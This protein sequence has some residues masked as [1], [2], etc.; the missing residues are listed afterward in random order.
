MVFFQTSLRVLLVFTWQGQ[1][2]G[3]RPP[4]KPPGVEL[5]KNLGQEAPP[6]HRLKA[7]KRTEGVEKDPGVSSCCFQI[8]VYVFVGGW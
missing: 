8:D 4:L 7:P 3:A 2:V 5:A 1:V 6:N